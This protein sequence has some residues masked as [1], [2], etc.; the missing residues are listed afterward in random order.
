MVGNDFVMVGNEFV[1]VG[2]EFVTVGNEF[3]MIGNEFVMVGN[4]FA[5]VGNDFEKR[6]EMR[7]QHR[8]QIIILMLSICLVKKE[9]KVIHWKIYL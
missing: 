2:N 7:I 1:T 4:D 5:M 6:M 3:V 9:S 8:K